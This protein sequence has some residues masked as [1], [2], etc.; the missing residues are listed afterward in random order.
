M[1]DA[2]I[3]PV[4]SARSLEK[5]FDG[6]V[7]TNNV[8]LDVRPGEIHGVIGPNGAGKST[9]IAQLSGELASDAGQ[10]F[11]CGQDVTNLSVHRRAVIGI[12]RSYQTT[13][14]FPEISVLDNVALGVQSVAG[15]SFR[16]WGN[17]RREAVLRDPALC[18][19]ADVGL[20]HCAGEQARNLAHGEKRLV[21]IAMALA[22]RPKVLLLD[23]P[24]A[25][26]GESEAK[27]IIALIGKLKASVPILLVEHDMDAVF[28]LADRITV[29]VYG[30][31][32]ASGLP[33]EISANQEVRMAYLSEED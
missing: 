10:V 15:H 19:L 5:R 1:A 22:V 6:V 16:F 8:D 9:L 17:A 11:L 14:I 18:I 28:A 3:E 7:A 30:K 23:E 20:E 33:G 2:T 31:V 13:S 27:R 26:L 12:T 29:L 24:L 25:G 32:I 21:E 4:L